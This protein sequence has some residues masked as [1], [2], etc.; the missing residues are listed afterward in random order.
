MTTRRTIGLNFNENNAE[1]S[2]WAPHA[3]TVQLK[4]SANIIPLE[5]RHQGFWEAHKLL[6]KPGTQY[7]VIIDGKI[8]PDPACLYLPDGVDGNSVAFDLNEHIW[9]DTD[10][11]GILPED[12]IIYELH[13]GTFSTDGTFDGIV[14]KL[15]YLK[16]L[17]ITAIEIMPVAQFSGTRNWGYDGVFP[18]AVQNSYGG[19]STLQ[20]LVDIS[21]QNGIAVILDVVMN[22]IGPEGNILPEFG[23]IFTE[24][25]KTPWGRAINFDDE[26]CDGVRRFFIE[27]VLMWLR[28]FH[29][30]GLRLDA[31]HAIHD[32]SPKNILQEL[33]E[34][35]AV[36][37]ARTSASHFLIIECDLNDVKYITPVNK[38]GF[39]ID[40]TWSD[41][42]HHALHSVVSRESNGYYSDFGSIWHV[43]KAFNTGFVY[44]GIWSEHRKKVFGTRTT[45]FGGQQFVV[46]SQN[47][48]QVGN[49]ML[50]DRLAKLISFEQLKL[51]AGAVLFSP[52]IPLLF[53]GEEYAEKNPFLYFTSHSGKDLIRMVR[54]GR[55][56]EFSAFI[57]ESEAP[58]PQDIKTFNQS[59][60]NLNQKDSQQNAMLAYYR[61]LIRM[62]QT[63]PLWKSIDRKNFS[64]EI[65]EGT[66]VVLLNRKGISQILLAILNF[67]D[68]PTNVITCKPYINWE[69]LLNSADTRWQGPGISIDP[70]DPTILVP[71]HTMVIL[72]SS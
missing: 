47:H 62:R 32:F 13:T 9:K 26:W 18:F 29:I 63:I 22:H 40:A 30:D 65:I 51:I 43:V 6:I 45:G 60:L 4:T 14:D 52:F 5:R 28:D 19:P 7:S 61:E 34:N 27:N 59:R 39:G 50:G 38:G 48:D 36:L 35:V 20:R 12:L 67:D 16:E 24:K 17:G 64:A 49:R 21:H 68:T 42:F 37:N 8:L 46:F 10:W 58:D 23:P 66:K 56:K 70:E 57:S 15:G 72:Y 3:T 25:Y 11:P 41:E 1:F 44:D 33:H 71:A 69:L 31:V 54:E 53:M 2:V 55:A